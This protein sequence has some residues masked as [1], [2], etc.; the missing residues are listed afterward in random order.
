[1]AQPVRSENRANDERAEYER[2][3]EHDPVHHSHPDQD[4]QSPTCK[5]CP[6]HAPFFLTEVTKLIR[7]F[8]DGDPSIHRV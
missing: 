6:H 4:P 5:A 1:M 2:K 3:E 7:S 8:S